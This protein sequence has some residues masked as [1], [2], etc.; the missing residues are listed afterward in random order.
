MS[1]INQNTEE[2]IN[3]EE[4]KNKKGVIVL[5]FLVGVLAIFS[6]FAGYKAFVEGPSKIAAVTVE[7]DTERTRADKLQKE[8]DKADEMLKGLGFNDL[9]DLD[10]LSD[11]H[12]ALRAEALEQKNKIEKLQAKINELLSLS[13]GQAQDLD[14]FKDL[15]RKLKSEVW[16]LK[17]QIRDLK[18]RNQELVAENARLKEEKE[19]IGEELNRQKESN[20]ALYS[21]ASSLKQKVAIGERLQTYDMVAEAVS[22]RRNGSEKSTQRA[23]RAEKLRVAFTISKNE[24]TKS[25]SKKVYL[26]IIAPNDQTITDGG[27]NFD[28]EGKSLAYTSMDEINYSNSKKDVVMYA[29]DTFTDGFSSGTY[30]VEIY[31]EGSKIGESSFELK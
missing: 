29:K 1:E 19:K 28:V 31:C 27:S 25:G 26:R 12:K 17:S 9:T 3:K 16:Q 2:V 20:D 5:I 23:K 30:N 4:K 6:A 11:E 24:L 15:Y 8:I 13:D 10:S 22:V 14:S 18:A 7:K 21:E